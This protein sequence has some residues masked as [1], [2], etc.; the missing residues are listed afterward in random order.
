MFGDNGKRTLVGIHVGGKGCG[1]IKYKDVPKWWM[2][3][4]EF[5]NY[6]DLTLFLDKF[7]I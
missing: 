3:V 6:L 5:F 2:R 4:S 1:S 7:M